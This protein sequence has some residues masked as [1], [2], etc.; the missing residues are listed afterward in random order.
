[1]LWTCKTDGKFPWNHG[2]LAS[3]TWP[4][5]SKAG[6]SQLM[7]CWNVMPNWQI[8]L[9]T[10]L[11]LTWWCSRGTCLRVIYLAVAVGN[12]VSVV[13]SYGVV[14]WSCIVLCLRT[15]QS[16]LS[17]TPLENE[18]KNISRSLGSFNWVAVFCY[19]IMYLWSILL[20]ILLRFFFWESCILLRLHTVASNK[21]ASS[22]VWM[23]KAFSAF[24]QRNK[25]LVS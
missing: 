20:C 3:L 1:M 15:P 14:A 24:P 17:V 7:A 9:Q 23:L 6:P 19:L 16:L 13:Q 5:T 21:S 22:V 10:G 4:L 11:C 2:L 12:T 25:Y 18:K 8:M